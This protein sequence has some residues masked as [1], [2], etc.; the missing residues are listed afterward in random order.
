MDIIKNNP[1]DIIKD[2]MSTPVLSVDVDTSVEEVAKEML[3][4]GVSCLLVNEKEDSVG[5]IT[6]TDLV[7]RVIAKG[8]DARTTKIQ[9]AMSKP[10]ISINPYYDR[11]DANNLMRRNKIKHLAVTNQRKIVGI[12]TPNDMLT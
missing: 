11:N 9:S 2:F 10:I 6:S 4:K 12:L 1:V 7:K 8:L 5:I 3:E